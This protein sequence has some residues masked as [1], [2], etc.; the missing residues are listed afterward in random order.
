MHTGIFQCS[1]NSVADCGTSFNE[2]YQSNA[3]E[4]LE[5]QGDELIKE[6]LT[7][8]EQQMISW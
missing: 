3:V 6:D 1:Q 4:S 5:L 8:L 7:E 2:M